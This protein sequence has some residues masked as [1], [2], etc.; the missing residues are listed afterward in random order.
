LASRIFLFLA[1]CQVEKKPIG[2]I[3]S[4]DLI[5]KINTMPSAIPNWLFLTNRLSILIDFIMFAGVFVASRTIEKRYAKTA[6]WSFT[7][8]MAA[9]LLLTTGLAKQGIFEPDETKT[10]PILPVLLLGLCGSYFLFTKW[11]IFRILLSSIPASWLVIIQFFRV[12]GGSFLILCSQKLLP[13]QFAL[14]AGIGDVFIAVDSL[15][16]AWA[17]HNKKTWAPVVTKWWCYLG[18][19]DLIIAV[20]M[21]GL[22]SPSTLHNL[23]NLP[24]QQTNLLIGEYPL[25]MI[26]IYRVPFAIT[27]HL[28]VLKKLKTQQTYVGNEKATRLSPASGS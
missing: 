13:P 18:I 4:I 21:G 1:I 14:P 17:L 7:F 28:L 8:F 9:W 5:I 6:F 19:L 27:L 15:F 25:V 26:P 3:C 22:T 12:L 2:R 16:V 23:V 24:I 10:N 20:T 11:K